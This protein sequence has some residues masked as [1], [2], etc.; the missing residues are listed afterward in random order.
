[1]TIS[2]V[3]TNEKIVWKHG[4]PHK[5]LYVTLEFSEQTNTTGTIF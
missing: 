2:I 5:N 4:R 1:M 3:I